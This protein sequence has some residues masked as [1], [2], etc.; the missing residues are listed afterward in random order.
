MFGQTNHVALNCILDTDT[1][2]GFKCT[3]CDTAAGQMAHDDNGDDDN[4][5]D[6][7]D[8]VDDDKNDSYEYD[9]NNDDNECS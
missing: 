1:P 6:D 7:N 8:D 9:D 3:N 2:C 4:G 5:D